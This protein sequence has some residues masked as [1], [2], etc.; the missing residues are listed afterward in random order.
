[1]FDDLQKVIDDLDH[2]TL[3]N[4]LLFKT[5]LLTGF[6]ALM[7]LGNLTFPDEFRLQ[8]EESH[9]TLIGCCHH[10]AVQISSTST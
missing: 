7:R 2:S 1:M 9:E 8:L 10:W 6:F 5:M 3:H 4:D